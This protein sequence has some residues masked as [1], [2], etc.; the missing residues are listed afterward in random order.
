MYTLITF[1]LLGVALGV[2]LNS[3]NAVQSNE[4]YVLPGESYPTI[5]DLRLFFNPDNEAYFNGH[6]NIRII[7]EY[8]TINITLHAMELSIQNIT[9]YA[10]G[11]PNVNLTS[12]YNLQNDDTHFLRIDSSQML[13]AAQPYI[14]DIHYLGSYAPN[15]FG[16]Y[17]SNYEYL[18]Q[19]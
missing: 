6:A 1:C 2:P 10:V 9:L 16:L 4:H 11:S 3:N 19:P 12:D 15:M 14:L 7:P 5:Y 18:N 13:V 8:N 17:V